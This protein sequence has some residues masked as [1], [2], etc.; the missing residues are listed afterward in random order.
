MKR[1]IPI[2]IVIAVIVIGVILS[3]KFINN[4][5]TS[6]NTPGD[7]KSHEVI[8][9]EE[10]HENNF[11]VY[12]RVEINQIDKTLKLYY[13]RKTTDYNNFTSI[14]YIYD[15]LDELLEKINISSYDTNNNYIVLNYNSDL[16]KAL[17]YSVD[18][19]FGPMVG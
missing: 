7:I 2:F 17:H 16:S 1:F 6:T 19:D 13:L 3:I 4:D 11:F 8:T 15:D 12:D 5:N 10:L 9:I 18:L 14:I